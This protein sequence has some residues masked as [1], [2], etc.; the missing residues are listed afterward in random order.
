[1]FSSPD[2]FR[3]RSRALRAASR[4]R[5]ALTAFSMMFRAIGW[6]LVEIVAEVLVD[7]RS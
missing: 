4:A 3:I 6:V 5:A 7:D 1:M 2:F